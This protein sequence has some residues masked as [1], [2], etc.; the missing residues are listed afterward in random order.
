MPINDET[1]LNNHND[2]AG[3]SFRMFVLDEAA[4]LSELNGRDVIRLTLGKS[5]LPLH[6][7]ISEAIVSTIL[8][9]V[10]SNFVFPLGLPELRTAISKE[11]NRV[12]NVSIPAE[13]IIIDAGTSSAYPALFRMLLSPGDEVLLPLPYYP[14]YR[15]SA[16][17]AG[18]PTRYYK[19][20]LNTLHPDL[21]LFKSNVNKSIR[22]VVI[23]SPG[24]PLGNIISVQDLK[25]IIDIMPENCYLIF[26]EIYENVVFEPSQSLTSYLLKQTRLDKSKIIITNSFS[27][28]YRMYTKRVGWCILPDVLLEPMRVILH[29][30]RLTVD[31]AVQYGAIEALGHKEE[32]DQL[33]SIHK[34]RWDYAKH[35][36]NKITGIH[37]YPSAGGFYCTLD[38]QEF[39]RK[40]ELI[41]CLKLS[42]N[43][44]ERTGVASVPGEDFGLPGTLRLSFTASRFEEAIN[45]LVE[46][47]SSSK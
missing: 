28:G 7:S 38:C 11:Y 42:L 5:D 29:H 37:L 2:G 43:I 40:R 20:N 1:Y 10:K 16:L 41:D 25:N 18:A 33:N 6:K 4:R 26:D 39:I 14:L 12:Y 15:I 9:P 24:N 21:E 3:N 30:T 13:N 45:R 32:V 22:I 46:Y 35:H 27:K 36:L 19:I 47:F 31:P 8:D 34:S 17:L 44:L 23:N